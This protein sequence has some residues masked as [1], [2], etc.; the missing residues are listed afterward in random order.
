MQLVLVR[1][2]R[3]QHLHVRV[4]HPH[5]QPFPRGTIAQ[6]KYLRRE[7]VLLQLPPFPEVPRAHRV[8]QAA[9]PQ[10]GAVRGDVDAGRAVGVT[11]ELPDQG[12]IVQV[13]H[14]DVAVTA[15]AEAHLGVGG[16]RQGVARWR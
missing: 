1:L 15:A 5:R 11:L 14:G 10:L 7:V 13:P 12:L 3:V 9:G 4:F 6:G 8:V 2:G 16:Y